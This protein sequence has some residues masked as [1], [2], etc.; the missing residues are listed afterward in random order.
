MSS[1]RVLRRLRTRT[2]AVVFVA[3]VAVT[4][5]TI[6]NLAGAITAPSISS[7]ADGTVLPAGNRTIVFSMPTSDLTETGYD[8]L[9]ASPHSG[10]CDGT[11]LGLATTRDSASGSA[12]L[13]PAP[14]ID[15]GAIG[16][17]D[18]CYWVQAD[19]SN[20]SESAV[21]APV[22]ITYDTTA[23]V[24]T[25]TGGEPANPTQS[26]TASFVFSG[27]EG[28]TECKLDAGSF[29]ACTTSSSMD[30]SGLSEASHTFTVRSTDA[31]GN[32]GSDS[33]TWTVDHTAPAVAITWAPLAFD[34][35]TTADF[36]FSGVEGT[37]QCKLDAGSFGACST[38]G[39]MHLTGLSEA[40]HTFTVRSSD[41]AGNVG[42]DSYTWTVDH[43]A[44]AITLPAK[45]AL[46]D[47][48][49]TADF[50]FSGIEGTPQC[51]LDEC[52]IAA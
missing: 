23:P 37:P 13:T 7:P 43:T 42:S 45:P 30:L 10:A 22:K 35:S 2:A 29:G 47:P 28:T 20:A 3:L 39:S 38:S 34:Q 27:T 50:T 18:Y 17:G 14:L 8:L 46:S 24:V 5:L 12:P 49:T 11:A 44:P 26:T 21:S 9:R 31:A 41:A 51:K 32:V 33:Y 19:D 36:N 52:S 48:S 25:I 4:A 40:S 6:P 16:D 1:R 15:S